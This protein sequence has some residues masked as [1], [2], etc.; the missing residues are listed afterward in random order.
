MKTLMMKKALNSSM[1]QIHLVIKDTNKQTSNACWP[2]K[3]TTPKATSIIRPTKMKMES[4]Q[5]LIAVT[6]N[7]CWRCS[8]AVMPITT[9]CPLLNSVLPMKIICGNSESGDANGVETV[10][11][12]GPKLPENPPGTAEVRPVT[13]RSPLH[14]STTQRH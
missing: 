1:T 12:G 4:L 7:S 11:T 14:R 2:F 10:E 13:F 6:T 9:D 3:I 5:T 8:T